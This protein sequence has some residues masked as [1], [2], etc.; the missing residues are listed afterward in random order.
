ML[1]SYNF[2]DFRTKPKT[3]F[4]KKKQFYKAIEYNKKQTVFSALLLN[5]S[6]LHKPRQNYKNISGSGLHPGSH[7]LQSTHRTKA[8]SCV[9][10]HVR[11][12]VILKTNAYFLI[13]L[14][15]NFLSLLGAVSYT[16]LTLPT[17]YSV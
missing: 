14:K 2:E 6:S 11:K 9:F 5:A 17:I 13:R 8:L 10:E 4:V 1:G 15:I 12:F 7:S 3:C 16:H